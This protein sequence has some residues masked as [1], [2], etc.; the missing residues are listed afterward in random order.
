MSDDRLEKFEGLIASVYSDAITTIDLS[1]RIKLVLKSLNLEDN[2]K[3]S[4]FRYKQLIM[5]SKQKQQDIFIKSLS[6]VTKK[7]NELDIE[8]LESPICFEK[9]P[10]VFFESK[11]TCDHKC[12]K[13]CYLFNRKRI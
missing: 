7:F 5:D 3:K 12:C 4:D 1:E 8:I 9:K 2:I 13:K 6:I 10:R 11:F